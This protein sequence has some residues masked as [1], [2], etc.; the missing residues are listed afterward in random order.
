MSE[1]VKDIVKRWFNNTP[2]TFKANSMSGGVLDVNCTQWAVI[3][4]YL[5]IEGTK[6]LIT[7]LTD[8]TITI[9]ASLDN[10]E[11]FDYSLDLPFCINGTP[12]Q[13]NAER[14]MKRKTV[15]VTPLFYIFEPIV[16]N[17]NDIL[18][19]VEREVEVRIAIMSNYKKAQFTEAIY[20]T[21]IDAMRY[22]TEH[23]I[24]NIPSG[25]VKKEELKYTM[26]SY[27]KYGQ[28]IDKSGSTKNIFNEELSGIELKL[29]APLWRKTN[30]EC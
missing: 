1:A 18:N 2:N 8:S 13:V 3:N 19:A 14:D 28:F 25:D 12:R 24:A 10:S 22:L 23:F 11:R 5:S 4:S 20:E 21:S 15:K 26:T 7:D 27:A 9:D 29:N 30:C 6:Y 17:F 16:E